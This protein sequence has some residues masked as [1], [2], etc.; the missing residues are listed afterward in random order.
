MSELACHV[1][2]LPG[3][4]ELAAAARA[5][6]AACVVDE[7]FP[8][9]H[10][11]PRACPRWRSD[12]LSSQRDVAQQARLRTQCQAAQAW[13]QCDRVNCRRMAG[14]LG[15]AGRVYRTTA[16][17]RTTK[18]R[19]ETQSGS[20]ATDQPMRQ[21]TLRPAPSPCGCAL[22]Q[23]R[24]I[25]ICDGERSRI[26][27]A[28]QANR[29]HARYCLFRHLSLDESSATSSGGGRSLF[30]AHCRPTA[31]WAQARADLL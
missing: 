17:G 3:G 18:C 8:P 29:R 31:A 24:N 20:R 30:T 12:G 2:L 7:R 13:P 27:C 10:R 21:P 9:P 19:R 25:T 1:F 22:T 6:V 23:D 4:R 15:T 28:M 26:V 11:G 14:V 16:G 5:P